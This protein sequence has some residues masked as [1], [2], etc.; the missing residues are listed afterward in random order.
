MAPTKENTSPWSISIVVMAYN[1]AATLD[2]VVREIIG[3]LLALGRPYEIVIINDG[4]T[5]GT[6]ER[7]EAL[8]RELAPVVRAVHHE[9]NKGIGYVKRT[10]Y[11]EAKNDIVSF[12]PADGECPA[13]I[14]RDFVPR[15]NDYDM[16][17]GYIPERTDS[18]KAIWL[19]R[20]ERLLYRM[21]LGRMPE[22]CGIYMFRRSLLDEISLTSEGRGWVI[23]MEFI[24]RAYRAGYRI[25]S[26][27]TGMRVRSSGQS[28]VN[29]L[30][31]ILANLTQLFALYWNIRTEKKQDG[32]R[33]AK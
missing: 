16:V 3:E 6:R 14:I 17:L 12:F 1:E 30:R 33:G 15:M 8:V 7:A 19:A 27:P 5:D 32:K 9:P 23:Q 25:V 29:N 2:S 13:E 26:V 18:L 10:G 20:C 22:F 24:M 21:L 4:S 31:Y 28:K 11:R